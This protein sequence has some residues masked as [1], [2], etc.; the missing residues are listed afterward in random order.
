MILTRLTQELDNLRKSSDGELIVYQNDRVVWK[1][2]L[3]RGK[4][5]YATDRF[6]PVRRWDRALKQHCPNWHW[7]VDSS[8]LS[9]D[10]SWECQLLT[11]GFSQ[12][13]LSL[14]QAKLAIR[15]VVQE[16]LF[17]LSSYTDWNSEWKP[18]QNTVSILYQTVALSSKEIQTVLN[19]ATQMQQK[20]H[21]AGLDRLSPSLAPT[22]RQGVDSQT[23]PVP[24]QYLNGQF[25]LWDI[26][27]QLEKSVS[28]VTVSLLPFV[29]KRLL[30]WQQISDLPVPTGKQQ[31]QEIPD[32]PVPTHKQPLTVLPPR[33]ETK[34]IAPSHNKPLIACIEDSP[35]LA[36]TLKKILMQADYRV[37]IIPE[38]MR[39]FSQLI[40]H[41]PEL[42][43]LDLH[44]PNADG[45]SICKFL[46]E[47][48]VFK[49]TPI[50]ILTA[51]NTQVDRF[52]AKQAG[53]TEFLSKPPHPQE[54]VQMVQHYL[55]RE[56]H[57]QIS[58]SMQQ[59]QA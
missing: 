59:N 52:R 40:E 47:T 10:G 50:I 42:I 48:P 32:L 16:C 20:W 53:A 45:Y 31:V 55:V 26:A 2:H 43:L 27:L 19:N 49:K 34:P 51:R 56:T 11:Q 58:D 5:L 15:A 7:G 14:I 46:R 36:H 35:V 25:T 22:L 3:V 33:L 29:E 23:L 54:L 24:S 57:R 8:Q 12:K 38:P 30:Q 39:G 41:T 37:L 44:L 1:L 21:T 9:K 17:E 13:Q 6:Y 4:L 28:E 18:S